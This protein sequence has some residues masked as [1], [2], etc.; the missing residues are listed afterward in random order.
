MKTTL[1]I[2]AL[3]PDMNLIQLVAEVRRLDSEIQ[4]LIVD[5]GSAAKFDTVFI[6]LKFEYGC[7]LCRHP[8]NYGKGAALKTG[9]RYM[10]QHLSTPSGFI[11]AD[12]D[13]QHSAEDILKIAKAMEEHPDHIILGTRDLMQEGVPLKSRWGNMITA[14]IFQLITGIS[15][16]DTQ[17]GLRGIPFRY[18][19]LAL[20][21]PGNRYEYET[22]FLLR[23]ANEEIPI[24]EITISTIYLAN[25]R[26]SHFRPARDAVRIY[27]MIAQYV[28]R[29]CFRKQKQHYLPQSDLKKEN[30][31]VRGR[32]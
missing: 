3:N 17:T 2:P 18:A 19:D 22:H 11:T 5:D 20:E 27:G 1:I 7:I 14:G 28:V 21:T 26:G 8:E 12:A 24:T 30:R 23:T 25:N 6:R 31:P 29:E 16:A 15:C 9:I 10:M 32:P 4:V 13:G